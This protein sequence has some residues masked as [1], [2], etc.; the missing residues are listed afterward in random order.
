MAPALAVERLGKHFGDVV[1]VD[2]LSFSVQP[3]EVCG[4]LGP[5]GAGKTTTVRILLGLVHATSGEAFLLGEPASSG[6][7]VLRRT[8]VLV[9]EPAFV[10]H[11]PGLKN[12][13]FYW[14][15]GGDDWPAPNLEVALQIAG[16]QDAIHRKVKTYSQGMRQRLG[17]AQALLHKPELLVLDE[18]TNGL[19]PGETRKVRRSLKSLANEGITVLLSSHLLAEVE[20]VCSHVVVMDRGK[21]VT[22]GEVTAI[23]GASTSVY[24]EVGDSRRATELLTQLP[25]VESVV[26]DAPGLIL[27]LDGIERAEVVSAL[28]RE[29]VAVSTVATRNRLEEAFLGLLG[30]S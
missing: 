22:A 25:G 8:G 11:L 6:A 7:A 18:P 24:I 20:Q 9:E 3:G 4:L 23:M 26:A 30:K 5:N 21:L 10:P 12:L 19:D 27:E 15:S 17:I 14:R 13:E 1:A 16:L 29:G 28:V 2:D